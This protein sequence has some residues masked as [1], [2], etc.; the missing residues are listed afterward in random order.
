MVHTQL[1]SLGSSIFNFNSDPCPEAKTDASQTSYSRSVR[2]RPK[3]F[4]DGD[5]EDQ[6]HDD[7][8]GGVCYDIFMTESAGQSYFDE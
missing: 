4:D 6:D 1:L 2:V 5:V 7:V 8:H 3:G